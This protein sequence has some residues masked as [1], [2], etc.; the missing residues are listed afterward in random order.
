MTVI[1]INEQELNFT[2]KLKAIRNLE[3][4]QGKKIFEILKS[5]EKVE[6]GFAIDF[7]LCVDIAVEGTGKTSEEIEAMFDTSGL[8]G[9]IE[10]IKAFS[11]E[12]TNWISPNSQTPA[13]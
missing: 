13:N 3:K 1:K 7:D 10:V 5:F 8:P 4:K 11:L 2:F 12:V 6:E 9:L